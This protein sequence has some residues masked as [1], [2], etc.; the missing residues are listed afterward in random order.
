MADPKIIE[1]EAPKETPLATIGDKIYVTIATTD[2][3]KL[4]EKTAKG[5]VEISGAKYTASEMRDIKKQVKAATPAVAT[6]NT[7]VVVKIR[8][9]YSVDDE[10]KMLRLAPSQETTEWNDYV[11]DCRQWGREEKAKL[12]L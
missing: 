4:A 1:V 2:G 8:E 3:P 11:E 9:K 10:I 6:I 5:T 12:G 7:Q